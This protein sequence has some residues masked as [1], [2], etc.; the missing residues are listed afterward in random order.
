M[1]E[2]SIVSSLIDMCEEQVTQNKGK[3][4][5]KL[6]LAI[7]TLSGVEV[8]LLKSSYETFREG[9]VCERAVMEVDI[10]Q[11]AAECSECGES[12]EA[13]ELNF[14]CPKCGS[15]QTKLTKG[16]EMHL[17]SLEIES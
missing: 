8:E 16:K 17:M 10:V 6:K 4:V 14:L 9:T 15:G 7:G 11:P 3:K 1:H 13:S 12:F 2:Y 5:T